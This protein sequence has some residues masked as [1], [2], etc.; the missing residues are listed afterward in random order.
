MKK[1]ILAI[2]VAIATVGALPAQAG[3]SSYS[4]S[5][6]AEDASVE[7]KIVK[8]KS[9]KKKIKGVS[10]KDVE[11]ECEGEDEPVPLILEPGGS[12]K[13][14]KN[15][16]KIEETE[17]FVFTFRFAGS[18]E[19]GG[20]AMGTMEFFGDVGGFGEPEDVRYCEVSE[21]LWSAKK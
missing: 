17:P 16:F 14:K 19:K 21:R 2:A 4:G 7:F 3:T 1:M 20:K 9:G 13:V 5:I 15:K 18:L 12:Y 10:V 6:L 8:K 11:A